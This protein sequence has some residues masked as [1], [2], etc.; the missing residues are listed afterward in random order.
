MMAL[1]RVPADIRKQGGVAR[2]FGA[3][4]GQDGRLPQRCCEFVGDTVD[5]KERLL[6]R[7]IVTAYEA[8]GREVPVGRVLREDVR[9]DVSVRGR[10]GV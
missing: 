8:K 7:C 5:C 3:H 1:E 10:V 2:L 9:E 6:A 4:D